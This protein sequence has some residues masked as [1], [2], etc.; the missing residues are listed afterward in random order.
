MSGSVGGGEE[1]D[2]GKENQK[3]N[4]RGQKKVRPTEHWSHR[5]GMSPGH[6]VL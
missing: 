1:L 2:A 4:V 6:E 3:E 5:N